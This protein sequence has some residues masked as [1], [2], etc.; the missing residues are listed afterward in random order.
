MTSWLQLGHLGFS[1]ATMVSLQV[2]QNCS[3]PQGT[4]TNFSIQMVSHVLFEY[5]DADFVQ[6]F[7][8]FVEVFPYLLQCRSFLDHSLHVLESILRVGHK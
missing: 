6:E 8:D 7:L 5:F 4:S 1:S 3:S 2:S